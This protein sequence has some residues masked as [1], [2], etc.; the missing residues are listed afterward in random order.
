MEKTLMR[1]DAF[2]K[3][4]RIHRQSTT[5]GG[6]VTVIVCLIMLY[7]GASEFL[8]YIRLSKTYRYITDP[9]VADRMVLNVDVTVATK[10]KCKLEMIE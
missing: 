2:P 10:C 9:S 6:L 8:D 5:S 1:F 4:E 7:L 3:V